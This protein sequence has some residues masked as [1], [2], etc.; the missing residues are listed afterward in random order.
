MTHQGSHQEFSHLQYQSQ[1]LKDHRSVQVKDLKYNVQEHLWL[2]LDLN[3]LLCQQL[4]LK[5]QAHQQIPKYMKNLGHNH[6]HQVELN[7]LVP[8]FS[9]YQDPVNQDSLHTRIIQ[10]LM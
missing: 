1:V 5:R 7:N 4:V 8:V 2:C 3:R 9:Q 6:L 10:M